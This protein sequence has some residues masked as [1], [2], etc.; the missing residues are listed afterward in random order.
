MVV[1][2]DQLSDLSPTARLWRIAETGHERD[3]SMSLGITTIKKQK[4]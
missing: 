4:T 2:I 1:L 3:K